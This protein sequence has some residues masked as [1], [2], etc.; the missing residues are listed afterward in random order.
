MLEGSVQM[1]G[2]TQTTIGGEAPAPATAP[3]PSLGHD[4][5]EPGQF[6]IVVPVT[7]GYDLI[8]Q[9]IQDV[10]AAHVQSN[11]AQGSGLGVSEINVY[12]SNGK[13][14]AGVRIGSAGGDTAGGSS[15]GGNWLYLTATPQTD[16]ATQTLRLSDFTFSSSPDEGSPLGR[17]MSD[18]ALIQKLQDQVQVAYQEQTQAIIKSANARLTRPLADG[19]RSEG[20]LTAASVA[21]VLL[22]ADGIRL[23]VRASGDLRILYGL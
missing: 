2:M 12:P 1:T 22:L 13:I 14:V 7:I 16:A 9:K 18:P 5:S 4:V 21:K 8:R 15:A 6:A 3:L 17:L 19:F 23:D 20:H 11:G 10:V